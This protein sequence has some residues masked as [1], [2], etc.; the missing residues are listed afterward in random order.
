MSSLTLDK[1]MDGVTKDR[2]ALLTKDAFMQ[3]FDELKVRQT[4]ELCINNDEHA[5]IALVQPLL[6]KM[7]T[8][9]YHNQVMS[10]YARCP[11]FRAK[12]RT[13]SFGCYDKV[14][15]MNEVMYPYYILTL[16]VQVSTLLPMQKQKLLTLVNDFVLRIVNDPNQCHIGFLNNDDHCFGFVMDILIPE[17][18][19]YTSHATMSV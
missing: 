12:M 4:T 5:L 11:K 13:A 15:D 3:T 6:L 1:Q 19:F 2:Q 18:E 16:P 14:F 17:V 8:G 9:K 10:E 7:A